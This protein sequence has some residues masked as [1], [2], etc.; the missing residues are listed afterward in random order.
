MNRDAK[1]RI[2]RAAAELVEDGHTVVLDIGTT[3]LQLAL[4]LRGRPIT[5][6]TANMAVFE[7]LKDAPAT[8]LVL[9]PGDYDPVTTASRGT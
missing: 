8:H 9:L 2:A 5:V 4:L 3:V 7:A 6:I 1:A